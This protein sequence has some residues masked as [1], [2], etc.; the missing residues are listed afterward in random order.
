MKLRERLDYKWVIVAISFIM[1]FICLGFCTSNRGI[2]LSAI[3]EAFDI[4]RSLF[5]IND[6]CRFVATAI[7]NLFFGT[8][9]SK[10]GARKL[11]GA[12]FISLIISMLI[13][14][15]ASN[16]FVF[17][18]GGCFL[19]I[20]LSWTTTT[21]VGYVVS[22]WCPEKKGTIMGF[23]LAANGI[24]GSVAT[25][26]VTPIIYEEGNPFGF[27]NAYKLL[28]LIL[29]ITAVLVVTLFRN[30]PKHVN[31]DAPRKKEKKLAWA[32]ITFQEALKKPYFYTSA[33]CI[34]LTG[35]ALQGVTGISAAHMT[36]VGIDADYMATVVSAQLL[37]LFGSKFLA[38]VM[39]DRF[40]LRVTMLF[41]EVATVIAF[42]S[43]AFLTPT[44]GGK[45]LA[46]V[47]AITS[48][49]A[50]PLETIMLPLIAEYIFGQKSFTQ[51]LGIFVSV[52]TAGYAVGTPL[53]NMVYDVCGTYTPVLLV[54]V[55]LMA[56]VA[57]EVQ[58]ILFV[59]D[60]EKTK[61]I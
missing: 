16:I 38:G 61:A 7:I 31:T 52:N 37:I 34:F 56:V 33:V 23:I 45:V 53:V 24:G 48:A 26:I 44:S 1:V 46:V 49:L 57:I 20:G 60:K 54:L 21:M 10:Y 6:S 36:D 12:G 39:H 42:A 55:V 9:I 51:M 50:L 3:T 59:V 8:L 19:G 27:Q 17:Y 28:A 4:K 29:G 40:G 18:I 43:L 13:Y 47:F 5:S 15:T 58:R 32:G 35:A 11:I 30:A 25:Q 41:C 14:A 22:C 2:Y